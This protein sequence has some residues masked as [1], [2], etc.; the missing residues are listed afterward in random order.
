[1]ID[2]APPTLHLTA[3]VRL[4]L[5]AKAMDGRPG[6][7]SRI[8]PNHRIPGREQYFIGQLEF[9]DREWLKPGEECEARGSFIIAATDRAFFTPGLVWE[10]CE[11]PKKVVGSC[12]LLSI[13]NWEAT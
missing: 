11:G 6:Y 13:E 8:R 3:T 9:S 2:Q 1:M 5:D 7:R 10:V 4:T 12:K